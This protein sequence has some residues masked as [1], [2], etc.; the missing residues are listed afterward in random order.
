MSFV[1]RMEIYKFMIIPKPLHKRRLKY[2]WCGEAVCGLTISASPFDTKGRLKFDF[3]SKTKI[4]YL[5][6]ENISFDEVTVQIVNCNADSVA[7]LL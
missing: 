1:Q 2:D 4:T 7:I 6:T 3:C 5:T